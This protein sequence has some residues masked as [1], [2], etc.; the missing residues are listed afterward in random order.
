MNV[1]GDSR[2]GDIYCKWR[3]P[4]SLR[5]KSSHK[6]ICNFGR[7]RNYGYFFNFRKRA[8]C[9]SQRPRGLRRGSAAVRL[10][11]LW[12][13]NPPGHG[14]VS[15]VSVVCCQVQVS[16]SGRS[17]VQRSPTECGVSECNREASIMRWPW[18]TR[19]CC[20]MGEKNVLS[21]LV[22]FLKLSQWTFITF[23]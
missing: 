13:R 19:G 22:D 2:L 15:L 1:Q 23:C 3:F 20:A 9:Q 11:E 4:E 17:P 18:P 10:L 7:L 8:R 5:S 12:V 14:W 6:N 16:A 21:T